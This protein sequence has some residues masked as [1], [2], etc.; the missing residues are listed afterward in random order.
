RPDGWGYYREVDA[1]SGRVLNSK[2]IRR[3]LDMETGEPQWLEN[4]G[5]QGGGDDLE[6]EVD[7]A[8]NSHRSDLPDILLPEDL[9]KRPG[10]GGSGFADKGGGR[11]LEA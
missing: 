1:A 6:S 3:A 8:T 9:P 5:L 4:A 7:S 10:L 11:D 2:P